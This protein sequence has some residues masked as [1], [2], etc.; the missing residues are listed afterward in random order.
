MLDTELND[1]IVWVDSDA[2]M[3]LAITILLQGYGIEVVTGRNSF[4]GIALIREH[5]PKMVV[6]HLSLIHI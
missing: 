1:I 6:L 3:R 5:V 2:R 4:D